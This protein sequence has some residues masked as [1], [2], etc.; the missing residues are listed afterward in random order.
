MRKQRLS[1]DDE[2]QHFRDEVANAFRYMREEAGLSQREAAELI[3]TTQANLSYME[4]GKADIR[5][6]TAQRVGKAYGYNVEVVFEP[7]E[8]YEEDDEEV[9]EDFDSVL[10]EFLEEAEPV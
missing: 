2:R 5:L 8:N 9:P 6:S 7:F 4:N 1:D 10:S 3:G